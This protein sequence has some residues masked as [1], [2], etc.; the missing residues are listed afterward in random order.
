MIEQAMQRRTVRQEGLTASTGTDLCL[1]QPPANAINTFLLH[2]QLN[3]FL[4]SAPVMLCTQICWS[5]R[6]TNKRA[7]KQHAELQ[8]RLSYHGTPVGLS[9]LSR[10]SKGHVELQ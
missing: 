6:N 5:T 8:V 1:T 3:H 9:T 10:T 4:V 2:D 7:A